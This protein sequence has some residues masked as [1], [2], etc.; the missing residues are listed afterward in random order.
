MA[1]GCPKKGTNLGKHEQHRVERRQ[2]MHVRDSF[3]EGAVKN[4]FK[5]YADDYDFKSYSQF[6]ENANAWDTVS[7]RA[8]QDIGYMQDKANA[9]I[10]LI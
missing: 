8:T 6:G 10:D 5:G 1:H 3:D 9:D 2:K 4:Q 7:R